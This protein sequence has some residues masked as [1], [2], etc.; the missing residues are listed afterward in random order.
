MSEREMKAYCG[1]IKNREELVQSASGGIF[2]C[3]AKCVIEAGGYVAGAIYTDSY[4]SVHHILTNDIDEIKKMRGSKYSQSNYHDVTM[5]IL[6]KC[7]S[8][9]PILFSGTPCQCFVLKQKV[10]NNNLICLELI[11]NGVQDHRILESEI[12]RYEKEICARITYYTMRYKKDN[13][14]LPIYVRAEFE[15]NAVIEEQLYSTVLGRIYGSR[16]ALQTSCYNCR[17]KGLSRSGDITLGDYRGFKSLKKASIEKAGASTI[18]INSQK[19]SQLLEQIKDEINLIPA[20]NLREVIYSNS[21]IVISGCKPADKDIRDFWSLL[22]EKG[23]EEAAHVSDKYLSR[24]R[25]KIIRII[26]RILLIKYMFANK[27]M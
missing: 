20:K 15:N 4:K 21:R 26:D 5:Q 24:I 27:L 17:F 13:R 23:I 3:L 9:S 19:G 18:I 8:G 2:Y 16:L 14:Q 12:E 11:C 7:N 22:D 6:D 10:K 25:N 1:W